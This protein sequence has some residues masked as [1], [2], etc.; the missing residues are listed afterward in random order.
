MLAR[1]ALAAGTGL[2]GQYYDTAD[3]GALKTTRTDATVDF[4]W[5][6]AI[7]AG[8]AITNADSFSIAWSGQIEPEFSEAYTFHVVADDGARLWIDDQLIVARS[9][10]QGTGEMRGRIKLTAGRRVNLRLEYIEQAGPASVRLEWSSASRAREIIPMDR[11]Y[12]DRVDKAGGSILKEHWTG[13]AGSAVSALTSDANYPNQPD[14]REFVTSFECL[15][16]DWADHYGT[17]VSGYIVAPETG[18]FTFAVSGD[19]VVELFLSPDATSANKALV[20]SVAS[21]TGFRTWGTPSSAIP[22]VKG[23]RYYVELL[24]KEDTGHDHWSVGWMKPGDAEFS[25]IPGSALVQAGIERAQPAQAA[26]F[27]TLARSHP[28]LF[29]TDERF[30]RLRSQWQSASPSIPK[31]WAQNAIQSANGIL[32][33]P[34]VT[35]APDV[36]GTI[37]TES[38]KVVDRIYKLGLAW[39]LTGNSNYAERAWTELDTVA[40]N[41]LFPDWHPAHFLDTAEMTHACAIGYDWFYNYWDATRR[42]TIRTA[43]VE[44]GL[45]PGL[46]QYTSNAGWSRS[47]GNNWNQVCNGGLS[48]GALALGTE[49]ATLA[50][51]ILTRALNS[52]RPVWKHFTTDNGGWYEG[53]GY[54]G[55]TM[56][57]GHR[58][59][60]ALEWTLGSDFNISTTRHL[61]ESALT[62]IHSLGTANKVFNYADAGAGGAQRGPQSLWIARRYGNPIASWW[63]NQGSGSA[64]SALWHEPSNASPQSVGASPDFAFHG[65]AGTAYQ[66]Q[67]MVTLRGKWNDARATFVGI[68]AGE[69][70]AAHGNLDAGTFV[71][72]ALG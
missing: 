4:N 15:A 72:D 6:T 71:L 36:R 30:A 50:R 39:Q 19:D 57:Y 2:T 17:R 51:D 10:A 9:F 63:E 32:T 11:L 12:P 55:Y 34:P 16:Q 70:G 60:A 68:K 25:V 35:Y 59:L 53:P 58:M 1:T 66:P 5:G 3:F 23:G 65:E 28:R 8:T 26:L 56:E 62:P 22:L 20:A 14:G 42:E 29:A 37:L 18:N 40:D 49:S 45:T 64:L 46:A 24:H 33:Q 48:M 61:S 47:S 44:K 13:I 67:E 21:A 69:M 52:T 41:T 43:I 54:W 27:D 7:P 31:T 38:R